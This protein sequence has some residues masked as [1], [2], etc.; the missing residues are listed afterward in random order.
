MDFS[1][2]LAL[3]LAAGLGGMLAFLPALLL[4]VLGGRFITF[5]RSSIVIAGMIAGLFWFSPYLQLS[6]GPFL[7]QFA[8]ANLAEEVNSSLREEPLLAAYMDRYPDRAAIILL[9]AEQAFLNNGEAGLYQEAA[10]IGEEIGISVMTELGAYASDE[11]LQ[12]L[13]DAM[14][15][16]GEQNRTRPQLCYTFFYNQIAPQNIDPVLMARV[17]E[18]EGFRGVIRAMTMIVRNAGDTRIPIDFA[19]AQAA[20]ME[21]EAGIYTDDN[22]DD[23][24]FAMGARP[25]D[26]SEYLAACD[27]MLSIFEAYNNHPDRAAIIRLIYGSGG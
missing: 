24:R 13:F 8:T 14:V 25:Q 23:I 1:Q 12:R 11:D 27:L 10:I 15:N 20:V 17:G 9:R 5:L 18:A 3:V 6:T 7:R 26:D 4:H 21:A 16:V 19:T 2:I 22:E